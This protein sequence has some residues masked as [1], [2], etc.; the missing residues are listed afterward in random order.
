LGRLGRAEEKAQA[1]GIFRFYVHSAGRELPGLTAKV[2]W[3]LPG[4]RGRTV[5]LHG[6]DPLSKQSL[7]F[8]RAEDRTIL[9]VETVRH[10][11]TLSTLS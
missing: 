9:N 7:R 11:G 1:H 2:L 10:S 3:V 6:A 5:S 4:Q 8:I